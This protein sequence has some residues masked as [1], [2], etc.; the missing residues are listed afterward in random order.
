MKGQIISGMFG[1]LIARQKHNQEIEIGE[2]LI[3]ENKHNKILLQVTDLIYGSQ[4]SQQNLELISGMYLEEEANEELFDKNLRLYTLAK[5][6]SILNIKTEKGVLPKNLPEVFSSVREVKK[7]DLDFLNKPKSPLFL[8]KLRSGSR[9]LDVDIFLDGNKA[10]S[11]HIL[12]PATTGRGK[13]NL[14]SCLL[15]DSIDKE[16]CGNLVLDPHDEYFGR[17]GLGLKDHNNNENVVYYTSKDVPVGQRSL[18]INIRKIKPM[19]FKGV[20][21]W[22]QPQSEALSGYY[23]KYKEEWIESIILEK[24]LEGYHE[25]TL[26]V[27]KRRMLNILDISFEDYKVICNGIFQLNSGE[28][29]LSDICND[30]E[31][32][33]IVIIDTSKFSGTVELLI[34]SLIANEIFNRYKYYKRINEKKP[35]ISIVIEEAPRVLGKEILEKGSNIFSTIAREGRKFNVGLTAVTQ[36]P[37]LIP[38]EILANMNTK[39]ILGLEMNAER[40]SIIESASQD[41][42]D[43]NKT[44]ASLDVGEALVSSNFMK[45][46]VPI[47][48]PKFENFA[49]KKKER[50][51]DTNINELKK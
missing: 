28:N 8:G 49:I 21:H 5:M 42:S 45:F 16:Y 7:E 31:K 39:I 29:T 43:D 22:T 19:H 40:Q 47:K 30:L 4:I 46:A 13:S 20:V 1:N 37:S 17:N 27:L 38:R 32:S 15:W 25:G 10:F 9:E 35:V 2:L 51:Y 6:K 23:K 44:I 36:L 12:I 33:K 11:H 18:R 26:S 48:I 24:P 3:S 41:L 50:K 14:L 34:G